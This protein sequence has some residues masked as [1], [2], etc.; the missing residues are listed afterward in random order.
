MFEAL[1]NPPRIPAPAPNYQSVKLPS[2]L[3]AAAKEQAQTFRRSTAGQIEYWVGLGK[4]AESQ[5]LTTLQIKQ[6]LEQSDRDLQLQTLISNVKNVSQNG[7]L[8]A[9]IQNVIADN[10]QKTAANAAASPAA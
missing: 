6:A 8:S 3:V 2:S 4:S 10:R 9:A 7:S 5:G 1:V